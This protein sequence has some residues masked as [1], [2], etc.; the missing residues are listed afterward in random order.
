MHRVSGAVTCAD[1]AE[2]KGERYNRC[3][4]WTWPPLSFQCGTVHSRPIFLNTVAIP[5]SLHVDYGHRRI[6]MLTA[7]EIKEI[8][9]LFSGGQGGLPCS[10]STMWLCHFAWFK[11]V[12]LYDFEL[13]MVDGVATKVRQCRGDLVC[14]EIDL[15][16]IE[17]AHKNKYF[18]DHGFPDQIEIGIINF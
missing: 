12:S 17:P 15:S 3:S 9:S 14:K 1:H 13:S 8:V 16:L 5:C 11:L 7:S 18:Y 10:K 4:I 2:R 6:R